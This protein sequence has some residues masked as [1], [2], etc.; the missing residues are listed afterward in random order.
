VIVNYTGGETWGAV[1]PCAVPAM[2]GSRPAAPPLAMPIVASVRPLAEIRDV[3]RRLI[4][5]EVFGKAV[6]IP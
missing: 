4:D 3:M 6:Q 5:R 2:A 1:L